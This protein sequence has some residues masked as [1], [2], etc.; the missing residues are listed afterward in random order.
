[1][2]HRGTAVGFALAT[3]RRKEID[4]TIRAQGLQRVGAVTAGLA[5]A[6]T[7]SIALGGPALAA[8]APA[9]STT[10]TKTVA[11]GLGLS[12]TSSAPHATTAVS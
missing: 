5:V 9:S 8:G 7:G 12:S 3:T 1:M 4:M 11:A 2:R 10:T 6:V